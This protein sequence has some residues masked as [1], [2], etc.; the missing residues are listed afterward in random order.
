MGSKTRNLRRW[1]E[2]VEEN[3]PGFEQ[4]RSQG[5][6]EIS[7]GSGVERL[8]GLGLEKLC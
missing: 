6:Y 5:C 3:G 1:S 4:G 8:G 7:F 2:S